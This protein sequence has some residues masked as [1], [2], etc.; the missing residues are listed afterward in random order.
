MRVPIHTREGGSYSRGKVNIKSHTTKQVSSR[1]AKLDSRVH[2]ETLNTLSRDFPS[3]IGKGGEATQRLPGDV[4]ICP[5]A[6]EAPAHIDGHTARVM[7]PSCQTDLVT[8]RPRSPHLCSLEKSRCAEAIASLFQVP[9][10]TNGVRASDF[11]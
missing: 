7:Q 9:S 1:D 4:L 8:G 11:R 2:L 6:Y 3:K 5:L 10:E